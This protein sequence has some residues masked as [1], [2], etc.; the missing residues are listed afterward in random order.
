MISNFIFFSIF[1][2][3]ILEFVS[4]FLAI[5]GFLKLIGSA[6]QSYFWT[7]FFIGILWFYWISFSLI[8]YDFAFLIPFEILLIALIYGVIFLFAGYFESKIY[9]I[10]ALFMLSFV[11]PFSF[12]WLNLELT[13]VLGIFDPS[14]RG[15]LAILFGI[16]AFYHLKKLRYLGLILGMILALQI[17]EKESNFLPVK[18]EL[19]NTKISQFDKWNDDKLPSFIDEN[20][21]LIDD[22]ISNGNEFI[23]L[24]ETA[25]PLYLN[26]SKNL[27]RILKKYSEQIDI[28]IGAMSY[29]NN[30]FYNSAFL[31]SG[32]DM[33]RFDKHIL[34]PFGEEIP[35]PSFIKNPLNSLFFG[36]MSDFA[37]A[38]D[39]SYYLIK[40]TKIKNAICYEAT[41]QKL[42]QDNPKIVVA[43]SNNGWFLPSTQPNLQRLIIKYHASNHASTIYHSVNGSK[44]EIIEPKKLWIKQVLKKI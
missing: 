4:P 18:T 32:T 29:E 44:S 10:L 1:E 15:F 35:L 33:S 37:S 14:H 38:S 11:H 34:V 28:L 17:S 12:D 30:G 24:P 25:L 6:K 9:R 39:F 13:L 27:I 16:L 20:L 7:G 19:V 42:Y 26:R 3:L 5:Y 31:F 22:A 40:N 41:S 43:I 2:N 21:A 8:Y 23:I 36:G